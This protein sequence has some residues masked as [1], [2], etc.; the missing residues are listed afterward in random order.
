MC[1]SALGLVFVGACLFVCFLG[2]LSTTCSLLLD[3]RD[4][5][6]LLEAQN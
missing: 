5:Q 2:S 3:D 4:E 6:I 1:G